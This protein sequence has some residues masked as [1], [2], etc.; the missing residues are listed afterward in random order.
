VLIFIIFL[1][2]SINVPD[3]FGAFSLAISSI[4]NI[5]PAYYPIDKLDLFSKIILIISMWM[6]RL[7][8]FPVMAF[9]FDFIPETF[10]NILSRRFRKEH[11]HT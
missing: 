8:L 9:I 1:L 3:A 6:G 2:L 10:K 4:N 5:G 7:E 11:E